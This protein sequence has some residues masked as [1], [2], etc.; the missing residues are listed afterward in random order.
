MAL[1]GRRPFGLASETFRI[2]A[3]LVRSIAEVGLPAGG[4]RIGRQLARLVVVAVVSA[5]GGAAALAAYTVGARIAAIAFSPAV[6]L[7][8]AAASVVGQNIGAGNADRAERATWLAIGIGVGGL[9]LVGAVQWLFPAALARVFVPDISGTGL[10]LTVAYLRILTYGY[11]ALG[12]IYAAEAGFNGAGHTRVTMLSTLL[13]YWGVRVPVAALGAF[14]LGYGAL[15]PFWAVTLSNITA[16]V[17][18]VL[19]F[20]HRVGAGL[21]EGVVGEDDAD[22]DET[23]QPAS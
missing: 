23:A 22:D 18:L 10:A 7:G 9:A 4:Q 15:G 8:N 16:A 5:A 17:G 20:R 11:P 14:V 12:A 2:D 21:L 19:Y 13:Q 3:G 1:R 6:A